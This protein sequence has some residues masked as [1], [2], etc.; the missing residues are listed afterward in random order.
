MTHSFMLQKPDPC[1]VQLYLEPSHV[2]GCVREVCLTECA[3]R[4]V[5]DGRSKF[6]IVFLSL[7]LSLFFF[8]LNLRSVI[9]GDDLVLLF[10]L[11][12]F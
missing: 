4:R 7:S 11:L 3:G 9:V 1:S 5:A 8:F 6:D 2:H 12:A 10:S